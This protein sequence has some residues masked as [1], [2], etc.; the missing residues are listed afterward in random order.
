M[1]FSCYADIHRLVKYEL[2]DYLSV[3]ANHGLTENS[4]SLFLSCVFGGVE[5]GGWLA[6]A[7]Y[8]IDR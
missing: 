1:N 3:C 5:G 8:R 6:A 2:L 7:V 4:S